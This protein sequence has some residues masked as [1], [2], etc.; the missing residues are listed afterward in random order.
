[1]ITFF[2]T[3]SNNIFMAL[4]FSAALII[5]FII[6]GAIFSEGFKLAANAMRMFPGHT[7]LA[8]VILWLFIAYRFIHNINE[9]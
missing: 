7:V 1:M 3:R 9:V 2:G 6:I 8:I 4:G 5:V